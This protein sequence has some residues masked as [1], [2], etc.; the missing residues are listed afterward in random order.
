[1]LCSNNRSCSFSRFVAEELG[2]SPFPASAYSFNGVQKGKA[3]RTFIIH[4]FSDQVE[5]CQTL[6]PLT[7]KLELCDRI[8]R[9]AFLALPDRFPVDKRG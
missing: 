7:H 3:R 1:M 8:V 9:A 6:F 2:G 5:K 4:D